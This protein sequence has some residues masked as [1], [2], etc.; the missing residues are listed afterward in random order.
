MSPSAAVGW[1]PG[2]LRRRFRRK[3]G[4]NPVSD[5]ADGIVIVAWIGRTI[6]AKKSKSKAKAKTK[7][8]AK[9]KA[10]PAK[11]KKTMKTAS[12]S[13]A[14][15]TKKMAKKMAKKLLRS[16]RWRR[17]SPL[18][19]RR[20][21]PL[22][23]RCVLVALHGLRNGQRRRQLTARHRANL[24]RSIRR[25]PRLQPRRRSRFRPDAGRMHCITGAS[26]IAFGDP[27]RSDEDRCQGSAANPT[28]QHRRC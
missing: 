1:V 28:V 21:N 20:A 3:R 4:V 16:A 10:A 23:A 26:P 25:A 12:K 2:K 7:K 5:G 13:K 27:G 8:S 6:M 11:K 15:K 18:R 9:R 22:R 17:R 19:C 14:G 24:C